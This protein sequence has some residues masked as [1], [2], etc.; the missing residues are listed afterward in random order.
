MENFRESILALITETSANLPSDVRCALAAAIDREDPASQA[1]LAMST[2]SVNID[3]AV[4]NVSPVCQDTGM[5]TFFIHTPRGADQLLMK[6]EIEAA[7][8]DASRTG[9]L[10]PNAVDAITGKNSGNNLGSHF[11]VIHFEPWEKDEIEVKLI[12]KGGGCENKN[13]QY[14]IGAKLPGSGCFHDGSF[15]LLFHEKLI[16]ATRGMDKKG[17]HTGILAYR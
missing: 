2:I 7:V 12:L 9:K 14:R 3:M 13:I 10:R 8:V 17:W 5:P 4:D 15:N 6:Q 11:P 16:G 1:G